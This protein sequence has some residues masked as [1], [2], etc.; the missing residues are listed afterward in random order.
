MIWILGDT[1]GNFNDFYANRAT[2]GHK[3]SEISKNDFVIVLGDFGLLWSNDSAN[4]REIE[5]IKWINDRPFT[6]LFVDGNHENHFRL[7]NL[8]M[9]EMFGSKV[10]KI[11]DSIYH[12]KRGE[13]Y[14]IDGK[15]I[16]TFG[17]G[18]SIDKH[19]RKTNISW[20][21]REL[22]NFAEYK[23]GLDN[24]DK[25]NWIVDYVLTHECPTTAYNLIANRYRLEKT[26]DYDLPKYFEEITKKLSFKLWYFGHYHLDIILDDKF[27]VL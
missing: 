2:F 18:Q 12:L 4:S 6:T 11:S 9:V 17:G 10:G 23:N 1:H 13:V 22:P 3:K 20:W 27:I 19:L 5:L 7:D 24:L 16:F 14:T 25:N 8:E 26:G 21:D 15:K